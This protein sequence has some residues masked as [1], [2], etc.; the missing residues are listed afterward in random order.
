MH[1]NIGV[2]EIVK[3]VVV[4]AGLFTGLSLVVDTNRVER[5]YHWAVRQIGRLQHLTRIFFGF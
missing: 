1:N 2:W 4:I 3:L 5:L